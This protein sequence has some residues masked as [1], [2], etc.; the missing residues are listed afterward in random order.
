M[1]TKSHNH[2]HFWTEDNV[3]YE[4]YKTIRGLRWRAIVELDFK[5]P[6]HE[7]LS[8]SMVT[9]LNNILESKN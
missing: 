3:V 7:K 4:S 6:D 9:F 8:E 2:N 1:I 5:Y